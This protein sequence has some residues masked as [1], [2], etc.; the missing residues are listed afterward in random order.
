VTYFNT[1]PTARNNKVLALLTLSPI[2]SPKPP[3]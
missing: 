3:Y 1:F 2:S